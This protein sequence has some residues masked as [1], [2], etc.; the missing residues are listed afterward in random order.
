MGWGDYIMTSGIV[1]R[2]KGQNPNLQ[3]LIKEP[4]NNS[5]QYKDIF[6]KNPY[7]TTADSFNNTL[8]HIKIPRILTGKNNEDNTNIIWHKDRVAEVGNFY[9]KKEETLFADN[10]IKEIKEHWIS[11]NKKKPKGLIFVS[12]IAKTNVLL[13]NKVINYEHSVNKDWGRKKWQEFANLISNEYILIKTSNVKEG[14]I[15]GF[16]YIVCDFRTVYSIMDRCDFYIGNEGGL[17]HLWAI[18]KK[19]GIV[20]FGHWIPPYLTGYPF[21]INISVSY[22]NHCGSLKRCEE[23]IDFFYNL[24]P[25]YIKYLLEKNI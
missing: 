6:Y 19:K 7:I 22:N 15:N 14:Y 21:H 8:P 2:L 24:N 16:Y 13:D 18:T 17:S 5:P 11:K 12:D 10:N 25:E 3:I 4:F 23:C 1:R 20:F 9:P